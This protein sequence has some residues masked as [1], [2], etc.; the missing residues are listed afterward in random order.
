MFNRLSPD[1][2]KE[3]TEIYFSNV[4]KGGLA[5]MLD[6]IAVYLIAP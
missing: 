2:S 5:E 3:N 1:I 6:A 4:P